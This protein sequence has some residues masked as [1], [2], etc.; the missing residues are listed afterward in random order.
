MKTSQSNAV[1]RAGSAFSLFRRWV[2]FTFQSPLLFPT[3][4]SFSRAKLWRRR[5]NT[6]D[7][8]PAA[9]RIFATG[10]TELRGEAGHGSRAHTFSNMHARGR[11]MRFHS[12]LIS[13]ESFLLL[14][15]KCAFVMCV[16]KLIISSCQGWVLIFMDAHSVTSPCLFMHVGKIIH[17]VIWSLPLSWTSSGA[18]SLCR[19]FH[20]LSVLWKVAW[21]WT[22]N[23]L[24]VL[25]GETL[26]FLVLFKK[27]SLLLK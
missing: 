16:C 12:Q 20:R 23:I 1:D 8:K 2:Y 24:Y 17:G 25:T 15:V 4:S 7:Q 18:L 21:I 9:L 19:N 14:L 5:S 13:C 11:L 26:I 22:C 3:R 6:G 10:W 27:N